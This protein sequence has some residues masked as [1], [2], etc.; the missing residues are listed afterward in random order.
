MYVLICCYV[1]LRVVTG[2]PMI[3][4]PDMTSLGSG[5]LLAHLVYFS[6]IVII[7]VYLSCNFINNYC[8]NII[9]LYTSL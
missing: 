6:R 3:T 4:V 7:I 2:S 1:L 9:V 8:C 5:K